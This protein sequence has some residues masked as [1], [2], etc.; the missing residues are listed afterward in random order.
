MIEL[1][2]HFSRV[3]VTPPPQT[4]SDPGQDTTAAPETTAAPGTTQE[5]IDPSDRN[6]D[7]CRNYSVVTSQGM[8]QGICVFFVITGLHNKGRI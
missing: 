4:T 6:F 8:C 2:V 3:G 1:N 7:V 5:P